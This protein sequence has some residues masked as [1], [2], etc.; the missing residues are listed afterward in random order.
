MNG[1]F[2]QKLYV[3][4]VI[5]HDES[6]TIQVQMPGDLECHIMNVDS[7]IGEK[8]SVDSQVLLAH[9]H[10]DLVVCLGELQRS[11]QSTRRATSRYESQQAQFV[12]S[13]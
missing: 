13:G 5:G 3:A 12:Y 10:R 9:V 7:W 8:A 6:G 2:N 4:H 11:G 1:E